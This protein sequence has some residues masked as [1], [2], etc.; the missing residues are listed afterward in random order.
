[1]TNTD[2]LYHEC[3]A[4]DRQ[5]KIRGLC[6]TCRSAAYRAVARGEVTEEEL[7]T[8]GLMLPPTQPGRPAG[9]GLMRKLREL[10][11]RNETETTASS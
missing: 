10:R 5:A 6:A 8:E 9:S 11:E 3:L 1:M 2:R 7:V 4:C